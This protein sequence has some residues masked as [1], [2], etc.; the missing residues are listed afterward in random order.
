MRRPRAGTDGFRHMDFEIAFTRTAAEHLRS[1]RKYDQ[2]MILDAIDE[3]LSHEPATE[4]RNRKPLSASELSDWELRVQDFR[5][6]YD[7]VVEDEQRVVKIKAVGH[8]EHGVL[9]IGDREVQP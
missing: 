5:V 7:V 9:R 3:Q 8:K 2:R 4:T 6:F 1:Y